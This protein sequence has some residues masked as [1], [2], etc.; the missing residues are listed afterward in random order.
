MGVRGNAVAG[1]FAVDPRAAL[2]RVL[3]F[4]QHHRTGALAQHESVAVPVPGAARARGIVVARRQRPRRGKAA[5]GARHLE[6][7]AIPQVDTIF[8]AAL[9]TVNHHV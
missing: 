4:L 1:Q 7:A 5:H 9:R 6:Q 3:E 2:F 8:A